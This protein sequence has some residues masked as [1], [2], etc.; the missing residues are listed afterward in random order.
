MFA[1]RNFFSD[2]GWYI[3]FLSVWE[4][5][6]TTG[7]KSFTSGVIFIKLDITAH[8]HAL[9]INNNWG[10]INLLHFFDCTC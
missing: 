10:K 4:N 3:F 7:S 2:N 8:A 5:Q 1:R 9:L 6:E